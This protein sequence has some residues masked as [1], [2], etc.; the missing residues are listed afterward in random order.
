LL[1]ARRERLARAGV[2][3]DPREPV[4]RLVARDLVEDFFEA[5][6]LLFVSPLSRRILFTVLAAT[7][8]ARPP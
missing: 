1:D 4:D 7:S 5:E 3:E 2:F 8:S 6:R